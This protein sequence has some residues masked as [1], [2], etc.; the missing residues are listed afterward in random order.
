MARDGVGL[1][2]AR[3]DPLHPVPDQRDRRVHPATKL[4]RDRPELRGHPLLRRLPPHDEAAIAPPC[5]A[6]VREAEEGEG[7]WLA[8]PPLSP[9]QVGEPP[10]PK[11]PRLLRGHLQP[12]LGQPVP[13][14]AQEPLRVRSVLK[15]YHQIV[16]IPED[17]YIAGGHGLAPGVYPEV[18]DLV[19]VHVGEQW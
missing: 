12:E 16:G 6:V 11:P 13:E 7:L 8:L 9:V 19:Q 17:N 4:G 5:P 10:E 15:A 2:V 3:Q 18:E 1:V 14:L